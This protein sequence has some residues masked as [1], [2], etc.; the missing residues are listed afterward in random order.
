MTR[1]EIYKKQAKQLVRWHREG[2]HSIGGR[3]R[4]LAR[5]KTLTD[6]QAL[7]LTFPL[8]EAQEIIAVEAG[9]ESWAALK[10]AVANEPTPARRVSSTPRL[11]RAVPIIFVANVQAS[12]EFF[13]DTLGF[14]IDFLH[15]HPP[16]YGAVSRDS[17][18]VH[19][20]FVHEPVFAIG[21]HDRD[22]LIMAFIE[23]E[24]VKA[25]YTSYVAAGVPLEQKLRKEAWGGRDFIVRDLDGNGICFAGADK[26]AR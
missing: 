9:H 24:N 14:S 19:L 13:R 22:G 16:F 25:L 1:L 12:A 18:C 7:A 5:Y 26:P 21:T 2:N 23:V 17:A 4:G 20:K 3:I 8:R 11:T 15:G 6:R 10:A